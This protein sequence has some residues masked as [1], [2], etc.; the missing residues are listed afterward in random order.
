MD[1][2]PARAGAPNFDETVRLHECGFLQEAARR[3]RAILAADPG[4][5]QALGNLGL[6]CLQQQNIDEAIG[7]FRRA[8]DCNP[9]S[10][11]AHANLADALL[12]ATEFEEAIANYRAALYIDPDYA[13]AHYGL[14]MTLQGLQ[15]F[16]EAVTTFRKALAVD[17]DY[18]EAAFGLGACLQK[19]KRNVEAIPYLK[20]AL[21][22]DP[23][24]A[25]ANHHLATALQ[26]LRGPTVAPSSLPKNERSGALSGEWRRWIAENKLLRCSDEKL[27]AVLQNRGFDVQQ[28][29]RYFVEETSNPLFEAGLRVADMLRKLES[30]LAIYEQ[31]SCLAP[32]SQEVELRE[33]LPWNEFLCNYYVLNQPVILSDIMRNWKAL[34]LWSLK[35]LRNFCGQ[36]LVEVQ[37]GRNS[38]PRYEINSSHH[39]RLISFSDYAD[40]VDKSGETNDF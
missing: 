38:D 36:Q 5:C 2:A 37:D 10:A 14:G 15:R 9:A 40:L 31:L 28:A 34:T 21:E 13:E 39:K 30:L 33:A 11:E 18:A 22:I 1:P 4:H 35:Y 16:D 19:L 27:I 20:K 24:M 12:V 23:N 3:Y 25:V 17:P 26:E 32:L 7:L 8:L 29:L 6:V